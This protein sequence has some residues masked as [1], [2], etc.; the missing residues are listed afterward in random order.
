MTPYEAPKEQEIKG[1]LA[2]KEK[3]I[4]EKAKLENVRQIDE[5]VGKIEKGEQEKFVTWEKEINTKIGEQNPDAIQ[6]KIDEADKEIAKTQE[7][8]DKETDET[9]RTDLETK[10]TNLETEKT[11]LEIEKASAEGEKD[12]LNE[13][14]EADKKEY[15]EFLENLKKVSKESKTELYKTILTDEYDKLTKRKEKLNELVKDEEKEK[16]E[17]PEDKNVLI[18]RVNKYLKET[19]LIS[20]GEDT[21][22]GFSTSL[23]QDMEWEGTFSLD[24]DEPKEVVENYNNPARSA[25]AGYVQAM[26]LLGKDPEEIK[27]TLRKAY[28]KGTWENSKI[29]VDD[30]TKVADLGGVIKELDLNNKNIS[31]IDKFYIATFAKEAEEVFKNDKDALEKYKTYISGQ[32][33][34]GAEKLGKLKSNIDSAAGE[35]YKADLIN[36]QRSFVISLVKNPNEWKIAEGKK[37]SPDLDKKIAEKNYDLFKFYLRENPGKWQELPKWSGIEN[38]I[39]A[40]GNLYGRKDKNYYKYNKDA[41]SWDKLSAKDLASNLDLMEDETLEPIKFP[42]L[43]PTAVGVTP[44]PPTAPPTPEKTE[45]DK[46][47]GIE[48]NLK[49][50]EGNI[51]KAKEGDVACKTDLV[52]SGDSRI[53]SIKEEIDTVSNPA[54]K[55]KLTEET[56]RLDTRLQALKPIPGKEKEVE[57]KPEVKKPLLTPVEKKE[58][59]KKV[60]EAVKSGK[61]EEIKKYF[62]IGANRKVKFNGDNIERRKNEMAITLGTMFPD[63][64]EGDKV[65]VNEKEAFFKNGEFFYKNKRGEFSKRAIVMNGYTVEFKKGEGEKENKTEIKKEEVSEEKAPKEELHET[66]KAYITIMKDKLA[67]EISK[68]LVS[69]ANTIAKGDYGDANSAI[70]QLVSACTRHHNKDNTGLVE[71][72]ARAAGLDKVENYSE[73]REKLLSQK[74][75]LPMLGGRTLEWDNGLSRDQVK[76]W[77]TLFYDTRKMDPQKL[78]EFLDNK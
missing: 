62:E 22:T 3:E 60:R 4:K 7:E 71:V 30:M 15:D 34:A 61:T 59:R 18:D 5:E 10:K 50:L 64:K 25:T 29:T 32:L 69:I 74:F 27:D 55:Q 13:Q 28:E 67:E 44:A 37:V 17:M 56:D 47:A 1:K 65:V 2:P 53:T 31:Q 46:E 78:K 9:K 20:A 77:L 23:E 35:T 68:K 58:I 16:I 40:D 14:L 6:I 73:E 48:S 24:E 72:A 21:L 75:N 42:E 51:E 70:N 8:I 12:K 76:N 33:E 38:K 41:N 49:S 36:K 54:T 39:S 19:D 45:A 26:L 57:A 52:T 43:E 63:A 66:E 11:D